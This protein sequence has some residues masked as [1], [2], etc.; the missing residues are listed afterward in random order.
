MRYF[1]SVWKSDWYLHKGSFCCLSLCFYTVSNATK[2]V[3]FSVESNNFL[4]AW[5]P[6]KQVLLVYLLT[7]KIQ[8]TLWWTIVISYSASYVNDRNLVFVYRTPIISLVMKVCEER[9]LILLQFYFM[10]EETL[11]LVSHFHLASFLF[12]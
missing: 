2:L 6:K 8:C 10:W 11:H 4:L 7:K 1:G 5:S 12:P 9:A 3:D